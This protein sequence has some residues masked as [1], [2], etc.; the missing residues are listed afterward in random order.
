MPIPTLCL[1]AE[2]GPHDGGTCTGQRWHVVG[3]NTKSGD[4]NDLFC[5]L[6]NHQGIEAPVN[7]AAPEEPTLTYAAMWQRP[8][9]VARQCTRRL[10]D[11][12]RLHPAS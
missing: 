2:S 9:P 10:L 12:T 1:R 11:A 4:L 6:S 7:V 5:Q 8:P 3:Q